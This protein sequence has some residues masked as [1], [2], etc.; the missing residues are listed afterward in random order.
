M[1][2]SPVPVT[3]RLR[4]GPRYSP[5]QPAYWRDDT[6]VVWCD[7]FRTGTV[8]RVGVASVTVLVW[9]P[10]GA[11]VSPQI[12][13]QLESV[14]IWRIAI[15]VDITGTW[16]VQVTCD[17]PSTGVDVRE[18]DVR[19]P[20]PDT[21]RS[22]GAA[23]VTAVFGM[24]GNVTS[25]NA[26]HIIYTGGGDMISRTV[27]ARLGDLVS[28]LDFGAVGDGSA[29]DTEAVTAAVAYA[30]AG[31][32]DL[33]WPGGTYLV[34]AS[35]P[36]LHDIRHRG[37]GVIQAG[38]D[39]WQV[40]P[41][42]TAEQIVYVDPDGDDANDGLTAA[43]PIETIAHAF[44][45]LENYG[46]LLLGQWEI[47]LAA[48][49]YAGA[50]TLTGLPSEN[51][52]KITGPELTKSGDDEA[53]LESL[54]RHAYEN[55]VPT[56]VIKHPSSVGSGSDATVVA[57][58]RGLTLQ[59][60]VSAEIKDVKFAGP[61]DIGLYANTHAVLTLRNVHFDGENPGTE[62]L[63][64]GNENPWKKGGRA[65]VTV[66][67][68]VKI[69]AYGGRYERWEIGEY[70]L[71]G[72][73]RNFDV[74]DE[75]LRNAAGTLFLGCGVGI[76][77]K[78]LTTGHLDFITCVD[79]ATGLELQ[80]HS[81][82]NL[83]GSRFVGCITPIVL[84]ES[85]I[86]NE[87]GVDIV[88]PVSGD[89]YY[90]QGAGIMQ[91][92]NSVTLVG[93]GW[94]ANYGGPSLRSGYSAPRLI[95]SD[96]EATLTGTAFLGATS[97]GD[98]EVSNILCLPK[99]VYVNKGMRIISRLMCGIPAGTTAGTIR[100]LLYISDVYTTDVIIPSGIVV[101]AGGAQIF[102]EWETVCLSDFGTYRITSRA[103]VIT[104]T[105]V[106]ATVSNI[107]EDTIDLT[108]AEHSVSPKVRI[109]NS[110]DSIYF[111]EF[112]VWG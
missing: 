109:A 112:Q 93:I 21:V 13:P 71:F 89:R 67:N 9:D 11:L 75:D 62:P 84:T 44:E 55:P 81:A 38:S 15:P 7:F 46:P 105:E 110:A 45:I 65:G 4:F 98:Q 83:K 25:A 34:A 100:F 31:D 61:W 41:R 35:V 99:N 79:C 86:H 20:E 42:K 51:P 14:G 96:I 92:G 69:T 70:E 32:F 58:G 56:A 36:N 60:Y 30:Y 72:V 87:G 111:R 90:P 28:V 29:D 73:M 24:T 50:A 39:T 19:A 88:K 53:D 78:E 101:P 43:R 76:K 94:E 40:E 74:L 10:G 91:L 85:E 54:E 23:P 47:K 22:L 57:S 8:T 68:H 52:I 18:F 6:I 80:A 5:V 59:S 103:Q 66:T 48:G 63:T 107:A 1:V 95:G 17:L 27:T 82:S 26:D 16:R 12:E 108:D 3:A 104:A 102:A 64:G 2:N 49:D 97:S 33:C 77:A 106:L 37:R